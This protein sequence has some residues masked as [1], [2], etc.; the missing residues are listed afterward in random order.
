MLGYGLANDRELRRHF[1]ATVALYSEM[2]R[3]IESLQETLAGHCHLAKLHCAVERISCRL[4]HSQGGAKCI[5]STGAAE[6]ALLQ[7]RVQSEIVRS[8]AFTRGRDHAGGHGAEA[9][10]SE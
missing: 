2:R 6:L 7:L 9:L 10:E 3:E 1:G 8:H 4:I 5:S